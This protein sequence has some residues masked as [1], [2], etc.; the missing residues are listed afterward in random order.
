MDIETLELRN[1]HRLAF[2]R[3]YR[4][5]I[6]LKTKATKQDII[7]DI[8]LIRDMLTEAEAMLDDPYYVD[9]LLK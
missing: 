6:G 8:D 9:R 5:A 2:K 1:R 3:L 4:F 7:Q